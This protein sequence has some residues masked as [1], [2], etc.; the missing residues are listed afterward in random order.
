[1]RSGIHWRSFLF[2]L[3]AAILVGV[4]AQRST[5]TWDKS[6]YWRVHHTPALTTE[7]ERAYVGVMD[8]LDKVKEAF[9]N[10]FN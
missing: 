3:A 10:A 8:D 6:V 5:S 1:M 9:K 2:G 4:V 7:T